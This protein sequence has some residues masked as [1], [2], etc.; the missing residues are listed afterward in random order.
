VIY[1]SGT[2]V[3]GRSGY[4]PLEGAVVGSETL[5]EY[6]RKARKDASVRAIV[7]RWTAPAAPRRRPTRSGES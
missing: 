3:G 5:I 1:A 6:I 4:D 2:I 7:L